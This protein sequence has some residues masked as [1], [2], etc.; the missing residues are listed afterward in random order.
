M[1]PAQE[2]NTSTPLATKLQAFLYFTSF[3]TNTIFLFQNPTQDTSLHLQIRFPLH[4]FISLLLI[5]L[6]YT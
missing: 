5:V 3:S 2:H 4:L 1:R 6:K